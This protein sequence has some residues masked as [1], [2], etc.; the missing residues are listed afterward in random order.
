MDIDRQDAV[1]KRYGSIYET[2]LSNVYPAKNSTGFPERNLSVN[3][4]KA[5]EASARIAD[6]TAFSWF[7]LQFGENNR[8]HA[9]AVIINKTVGDM[10]IVES[11]RF[12]DP[13]KKIKE[14]AED[15]ERIH[16]LITELKS[17]N[18]CGIL[19]IDMSKINRCY[20]VILADV[21]T[22]TQLKKD[23]LDS[24]S[25]GVQ[26][27]ESEVSFL[28]KFCGDFIQDRK[29]SNLSYNVYNVKEIRS[30][31]LVSFLWQVL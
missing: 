27:P 16:D 29:F 10:L 18:D 28:N 13:A 17:E 14:I 23:I 5:Y 19:R 22:E 26:D 7:E 11:K 15:I 20:G 24:Y 8:F 31:N 4:S 21:W 9:D 2:I 1:F 3:F 6:E 12:S 30:Y 25:S